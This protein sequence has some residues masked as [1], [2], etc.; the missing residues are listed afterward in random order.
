M[1]WSEMHKQGIKPTE[2]TYTAK[3]KV[4]SSVGAFDD[5]LRTTQQ[6]QANGIMPSKGTW[7][8]IVSMAEQM[9]RPDVVRQVG[10]FTKHAYVQLTFDS[11]QQ[12]SQLCGVHSLLLCSCKLAF[13]LRKRHHVLMACLL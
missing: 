11:A 7:Q 2:W 1:Q 3:A 8:V 4:E 13:L 5:A 6:M 9:G 12:L 10:F